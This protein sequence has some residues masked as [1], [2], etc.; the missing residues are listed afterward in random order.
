MAQ[1][2]HDRHVF[3]NTAPLY[4]DSYLRKNRPEVHS[5]IEW[6]KLQFIEKS[7]TQLAH[8]IDELG[9]DVLLVGLYI[10]NVDRALVLLDTIKQLAHRPITIIAGGPSVEIHRNRNWLFDNPAVDFAVYGQGER[11]FVDVLDDL[12]YNKPLSLLGSKNVAW[13][14]NGRLKVADY[15]FIRNKDGSP[16]CESQHLL[17]QIVADPE[18]KYHSFE[19]SYETSWGCAYGCT[20]CDW[21]SGLD[22]K[23]S[24]RK[25]KHEDELDL[26]GRL[27]IVRIHMSDANFGQAPQDIE[28]AKTYARLK[29]E[30]GYQF[31]IINNNFAKVNKKAVFEIAD[32]LLNAGIL[33]SLKF[34]VQDTHK[35]VLD[36]IRRPDVPWPEHKDM[37]DRL[38]QRHPDTD[39]WI[40]LILGL[41]GQTRAGWEENIVECAPYSLSVHH[42][43]ILPN[44]PAGYDKEY[45]DQMKL[46]VLKTN[47]VNYEIPMD[48]VV[49]TY[50]YN[51]DDYAYF[52]L[53]TNVFVRFATRT[54]FDRRELIET[55]KSSSLLQPA[56][57][58]IKHMILTSQ[59]E[60]VDVICNEFVADLVKE[61]Y[62][63]SPAE[64]RQLMHELMI[65]K[66]LLK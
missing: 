6:A 52:N 44:A 53:L 26:L 23:V 56:L 61:N 24:I 59:G 15:E 63:K 39:F 18:Y 36:D 21:N 12:Y 41:P 17:E 47:L 49:E 46:R 5:S 57:D 2:E 66:G 1:H 54:S 11:A 35:S 40:E 8:E 27:G 32:I 16:F 4:L 25:Y 19:I 33:V 34:A 43:S 30:K 9:I 3:I 51:F 50:S 22:P 65:T 45:Q 60:Q 31:E 64:Y 14:N 7:P 58:K 13:I 29:Q 62:K 42:W 37:I 38:Q 28:V 55:I 10:W 48:T 20:F